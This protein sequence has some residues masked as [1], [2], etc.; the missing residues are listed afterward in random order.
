M[1]ETM[2]MEQ[3]FRKT[4]E[5]FKPDGVIEV[6]QLQG[7]PSSGYYLDREKLVKDLMRYKEQT[8]YFV[9]NKIDDACFSR[10]QSERIMTGNLKTTSDSDI[11]QIQWLLIDADPIRPAGVCA[12]DTEKAAALEKAKE[13]RAY[14]HMVGFHDPVMCDSGN[15]YHLLYSVRMAVEDSKITK[16][17]LN[18]MDL[19]FSDDDV[20][21]DPAVFNPARITKLYGCLAKKGSNT[22]ERPWRY[23][24]IIAVPDEI[25]PTSIEVVKKAIIKTEEPDKPSYKNGFADR[26][27]LDG[28][29]R[30]N[31]IPVRSDRMNGRQR[32]IILEECPFDPNHKAPDAALF[33]SENGAI[34]FHCFHASCADKTWQDV[35]QLFDPKAYQRQREQSRRTTP[36]PMTAIDLTPD[37]ERPGRSDHFVRMADIKTLDRSQIVSIK[38]GIEKLDKMLVGMNKGEM[39]VWSG[40]NGSGKSTILS[41]LALEAVARGFKVAMFSGEMTS[42]RTKGWILQQAAGVNNVRQSADGVSYYVPR[43]TIE[44]IDT[45]LSDSLWLYNNSYG[46][47]AVSVLN[48]FEAHIQEHQTDMVIIDNLMALD[49]ADYRSDKYDSQTSLVQQLSN[50]AK[51]HNVHV[52]FVCHPRKPT[53]FLRK[54]DISGTSDLTNAAD[55]VFMMHR[56]NQDFVKL[57]G[58]FLGKAEANKMSIYTNVIEVMKNRDLGVADEFAGLYFEPK[59]KRLMNY[60]N[61]YRR[62]GWEENA[63]YPVISDTDPLPWDT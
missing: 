60:R 8:W 61:E 31:A 28:F 20:K 58:D 15:G 50:L 2:T 25:Q 63:K 45:W 46:T 27:D 16:A 49:L 43:E 48:D 3:A 37:E 24:S 57:A 14:L 33:V 18:S 6:R 10:D 21:I 54:A 19:L 30:D 32:K 12:N 55:N 56:V 39:S 9:M 17:F 47:K 1:A 34:G 7:K 5:I 22:P 23:S 29:I 53:G 41:Q 35:R 11:R 13:I 40:G 42:N 26:F 44:A 36:Q 4:F 59:S 51:K 62:Y 52:H 38:T